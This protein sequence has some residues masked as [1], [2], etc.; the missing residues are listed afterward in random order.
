MPVHKSRSAPRTSDAEL[1]TL[2]VRKIARILERARKIPELKKKLPKAKRF[3]V[4]LSFVNTLQMKRLNF[5][6]KARKYATDILSFPTPKMFFAQGQMGELIVCGDVL[7]RQAREQKH[8]AEAE[9]EILLVHG[10]LHLL[11]LDHEK[12]DREARVMKKWEEKLLSS[13]REAVWV[14]LISRAEKSI[15]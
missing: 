7:R 2:G 9:L 11:G 15:S 13:K 5:A 10:V 3:H 1:E 14:S 12:G 6:W 4:H 8:S